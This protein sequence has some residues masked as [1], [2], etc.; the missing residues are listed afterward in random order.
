MKTIED[1]N[2]KELAKSC[3]TEE[4]LSKM[5]QKFMKQKIEEEITIRSE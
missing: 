4:D 1:I 5:S 2:F 3:K